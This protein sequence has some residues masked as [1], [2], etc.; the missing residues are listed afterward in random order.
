MKILRRLKLLPNEFKLY[1]N[2][3]NP[4][5]PTTK[6]KFQVPSNVK[7]EMS[8]VKLKIYDILGNEI[9]TLV[10]EAISTGTYEVEFDGSDLSSGIYFYQLV[11]GKYSTTKKMLLMK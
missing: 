6:I 8:N 5:N 11:A 1:Q 9:T 2:Y 3:P 10:N 7:G 4:F